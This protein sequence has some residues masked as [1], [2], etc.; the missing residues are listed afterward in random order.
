[1]QED[2]ARERDLDMVCTPFQ[3]QSAHPCPLHCPVPPYL[4]SIQSLP[5]LPHSLP[6]PVL[7]T[8]ALMGLHWHAQEGACLPTTLPEPCA[9]TIRFYGSFVTMQIG[10]MHIPLVH[11]STL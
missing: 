5:D 7:D 10:G 4:D 2:Q 6:A 1:M 3:A 8:P 9:I 11:F